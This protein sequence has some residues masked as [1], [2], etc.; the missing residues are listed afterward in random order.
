MF[1]LFSAPSLDY[2]MCFA[3][4]VCL[5]AVTHPYV[6]SHFANKH[7][8]SSYYFTEVYKQ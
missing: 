3:G 8:T 4:R 2:G 1:S 5:F 7:P 6:N